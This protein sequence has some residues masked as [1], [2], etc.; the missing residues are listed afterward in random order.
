MFKKRNLQVDKVLE[1]ISQ[2]P[3]SPVATKI[4]GLLRDENAGVRNL[5]EV[6]TKDQAFTARI[7]KIVNSAYYGLAQKVTTV[8][9]AVSVLG[10]DTI[11]SLALTLYTF[12]TLGEE[13]NDVITVGQLWEH[14]LGCAVGSRRI[15]A[16]GG[17]ESS[18]EAFVAGLLHDMGKALFYQY[19]RE[20]FIEAVRIV[21]KEGISLSEAEIRT[22]GTDHAAA[23]EVWAAK[24]NL[25]PVIQYAIRYHHQ[26]LEV[27]EKADSSIKQIVSMVH[28]AD[29]FCEACQIGKGGDDGRELVEEGVWEILAMEEGEC[30]EALEPVA[31]EVEKTK[32]IFGL[33]KRKKSAT[34]SQE[35][36][37]RG[38]TFSFRTG[39]RGEVPPKGRGP[40]A[41]RVADDQMARFSRL[42]EAWKEVALL[43]GL[44]ELLPNIVFQVKTLGEADA[45]A[46]FVPKE[47][48]LEV[49]GE[50]GFHG[51]V[52]KTI[53][54]QGSLVGWVSKMGEPV[55][56]AD[57]D[58]ADSS[59][60]KDFFGCA[61]YPSLLL[62]PVEW[63]GR[64]I[65][66]L[67]VHCRRE[68]QWEPQEISLFNIFVGFVAVALENARLYREAEERADVQKALN[69]E[70]EE[71]LRLKRSFLS[72]VTHEL[73]TP[74]SVILGYSQLI[75]EGA[76]GEPGD[77]ICHA[78]NK[79]LEQANHLLRLI[80]TILDITQ[81][82]GADAHIDH[83]PVD[84]KMLLSE[85]ATN[86]ASHLEGKSVVLQ[87]DFDRDLPTVLSDRERL[88]QIL[89]YLLDNAARFTPEGKIVLSSVP[90]GGGV[91]I[92]VQDTG[93]GIEEKNHEIIFEWFRQ[94]EDTDTRQYG[95]LGL[96]LYMVQR[97]IT[98]LGGTVEVESEIG[99]GSIFRVWVPCGLEA[100]S[101][102]PLE[103]SANL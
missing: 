86:I 88:K 34:D 30:R 13:K 71:A 62:L 27:P 16:Q 85:A 95:G 1:R 61:G 2:P 48:C 40:D 50:V 43:G 7:L 91:E 58:K 21:E 81:M 101:D 9:R 15:A 3:P 23:G 54:E 35:S 11:K 42:A 20:E 25:P 53:P 68:R 73:R 90:D 87:C 14:S 8:T 37:T 78:S 99:R 17:R 24:W 67:S 46:I 69:Q 102:G 55:A 97:L 57:F 28:L 72:T 29:I 75:V 41:F 22:L 47:D 44:E 64:R 76:L 6:I 80:N 63:A 12:G 4:L 39:K 79:V 77:M 94:I 52:G 38:T 74:M 65:A 66:V 56:I 31:E 82:E 33:S 26:P 103:V 5:A 59:W 45:A 60:E 98:L 36:S 96:G 32:E 19:F 100:Q 84:L 93:I 51:L 49:V 89:G 70:L 92:S 83:S 18:E 10:F